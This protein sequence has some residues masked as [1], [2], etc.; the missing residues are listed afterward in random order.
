MNVSTIFLII[1]LVCVSVV[2]YLFGRRKGFNDGF[3]L[4]AK[5]ALDYA[6]KD[7]NFIESSLYKMKLE[8]IIKHANNFIN[9]IYKKNQQR[10]ITI[11][12]VDHE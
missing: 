1:D 6:S 10:N 7:I 3:K 9:S 8:L 5:R 11:I 2:I 12:R 4:G